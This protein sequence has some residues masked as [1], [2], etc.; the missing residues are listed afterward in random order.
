MLT[1][2]QCRSF[3]EVISPRTSAHISHYRS[4]DNV[5]SEASS[6][7]QRSSIFNLLNPTASATTSHEQSRSAR[8]LLSTSTH[9]RPSQADQRRIPHD[10]RSVEVS[11]SHM[12]RHA[13]GRRPSLASEI[14]WREIS[15]SNDS[16]S[17]QETAMIVPHPSDSQNSMPTTSGSRSLKRPHPVQR[18][19]QSPPTKKTRRSSDNVVEQ[20]DLVDE[21]A[22]TSAILQKE[23]EELVRKQQEDDQPKRFGE[24]TCIICLDTFT[25]VTVTACG[26]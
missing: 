18:G 16:D 7:D 4:H 21:D 19:L 17:E 3:A 14:A 6:R 5:T 10:V 20:I 9:V 13:P 8:H 24:M 15:D 23:R 1:D 22:G 2:P 12:S 26:E 25:N 11:T